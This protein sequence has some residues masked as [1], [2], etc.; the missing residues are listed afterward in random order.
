M[1]QHPKSSPF[2][3]GLRLALYATL[4]VI[5]FSLLILPAV[6][7]TRSAFF[8]S[9]LTGAATFGIIYTLSLILIRKR[10]LTLSAIIEN[11]ASDNTEATEHNG[12]KSADELDFIL[13]ESGKAD[14]KIKKEFR[15][16]KKIENYRKEF[17]GDV[18]HELKTPTF[19]I[20]GFIETL[21]DG[22]LDDPQVNRKFLEKAMSNA[23]RLNSLTNDLMEISRLE[24][25]EMK[26]IKETIY[27][28]EMI[29]EVIETLQ[30]KATQEG[31]TLE[32]DENIKNVHVKADRNQLR[33]VLLNLIDNGIKY[34][35]PDGKVTI[36][37]NKDDAI[38]GKILVSV[39]DT[40]I[41]IDP[42]NKERITERF[43][44]IDKSRS[45]DKG[46]TGLGLSIVK[47]IIEAHNERLFIDSEP[48]KGSKFTFSMQLSQK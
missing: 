46:G 9:L 38:Y 22:A 41:G 37:F 44:R 2:Y 33:Q 45:R 43:Y 39:Q 32:F 4:A 3:L 31:I 42:H 47:H 28:N 20:Q 15:R 7:S 36:T 11:M 14:T 17:I 25:G 12:S 35:K 24:T 1:S 29:K 34:N 13:R 27:L 19:A 5:A 26:I 23:N 10:L 48:G 16:Y 30:H 40:G 8:L 21:L 6:T 18:S